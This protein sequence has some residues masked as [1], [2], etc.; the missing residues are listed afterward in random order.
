[1]TADEYRLSLSYL[2]PGAEFSANGD[3]WSLVVWTDPSP[4]PTEA[5]CVAAL[6]LAQAQA[7]ADATNASI[8]AQLDALDARYGVRALTEAMDGDTTRLDWLKAE[9]AKLRAQFV[10]VSEAGIAPPAEA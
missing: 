10:G 6:P 3:H 8:R 7:E 4:Q 9:K 2:R 1:M 5:E